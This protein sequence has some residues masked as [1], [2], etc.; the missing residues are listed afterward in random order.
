M[1]VQDTSLLGESSGFKPNCMAWLFC[2]SG[3]SPIPFPV[4]K[5]WMGCA[6][7]VLTPAIFLRWVALHDPAPLLCAS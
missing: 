1:F 7:Q 2:A 6:L 3:P 5:P 4:E